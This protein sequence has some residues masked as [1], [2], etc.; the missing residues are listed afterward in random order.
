M[1][2]IRPSLA[3]SRLSPLTLTIGL[4][5]AA[6]PSV[7]QAHH[8]SV[9]APAAAAGP[10]IIESADTLRRGAFSVSIQSQTE[11]YD[12][13]ADTDLEGFALDGI[14]GV[15][16]TDAAYVASIGVQY[17]VTD[18]LTVGV[19]APYVL[20]Y[21]IREGELESGVP[22]T[23]VLGDVRGFGDLVVSAKYRVLDRK[24]DGLSLAFLAGVKAPTGEASEQ[25]HGHDLFETE[26]QPGSGSWDPHFGIAAGRNIGPVSLDSSIRY[27]AATEGDQDTD[28]GDNLTYNF[29]VSWRIGKGEHVHEDGVYERHQSL[30]LV[31]ELNGEWQERERIGGTLDPHSG[32]TQ[33]FISP[34]LRYTSSLGWS[35]FLS[36][37]FP[38]YE[39][40]N[41]IQNETDFR[42]SFGIGAAF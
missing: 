15:H 21:G 3:Q 11:N 13:I 28:L 14:L 32:G 17:G 37:G 9:A 22:E 23:H 1:F 24:R 12:E 36:V 25:A 27:T 16:N 38:V 2:K 4:S 5:L 18:N 29:G 26:F 8:V 42:A 33:L 7:T 30:D 41:G 31:L 6:A 39:D 40:L 34:G 19:V 20:R 35:S 10:V